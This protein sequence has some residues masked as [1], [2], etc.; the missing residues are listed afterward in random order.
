MI[1]QLDKR[2]ALVLVDLQKGIIQFPLANPIEDVL[3]NAAKLVAAFRAKNLPIVVVNVNPSLNKRPA[4]RKDANQPPR[5]FD[6]EWLEIAP[7]IKT[8]PDDIFITKQTWNVFF[9]TG[10][11]EQLQAIGVTGIV[12]AGVSTSIGVEGT[13][14]SAFEFGY[15]IA[16]A[17]DAMTDMIAEAQERSIKYIFPRIGQV[18]STDQ[19]IEVLKG[20]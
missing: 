13:A 2:T 7:E 12:L 4:T 20:K 18:D 19:I 11:H 3:A 16:F 9:E 10:L 15:N 5:E 17:Q 8:Q 1:T 14:R 6:A